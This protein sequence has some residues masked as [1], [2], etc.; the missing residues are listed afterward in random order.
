[1]RTGFYLRG[2]PGAS[3]VRG[4]SSR[5]ASTRAATAASTA[6]S[7]GQA[8][9][10]EAQHGRP[11]VDADRLQRRAGAGGARRAGRPG[12][13]EHAARLEGVQQRLGG[14]A[15]EGERRDVRR[16]RRPRSPSGARPGRR[17]PARR[18]PLAR[19]DRAG[20]RRA[21]RRRPSGR[22]RQPRGER[23]SRR[24][25]GR[26]SLPPRRPRSCP[27]PTQRGASRAPGRSHSAP[28]PRGPCSLCA[29]SGDAV[30][31]QRAR[32]QARQAERLHGVDV[33]VGALRS[34]RPAPSRRAISATGCRVPSSLFTSITATTA[35]SGAHRGGHGLGADDAVGVGR[36]DVERQALAAERLGAAHDRGVLERADD[37]VAPPGGAR[38][39]QHAQGVRL[40]SAAGE[41]HLARPDVQRRRHLAARLPARA[42]PPRPA[43]APRRGWRQLARGRR[44]ARP[45]PRRSGSVE[46][47]LSRY[48]MRLRQYRHGDR[49]AWPQGILEVNHKRGYWRSGQEDPA[50]GRVRVPRHGR[51][52]RLADRDA[53]LWARGVGRRPCAR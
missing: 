47:A 9:E 35:V 37:E 4:P 48:T 5:A 24:A 6:A 17:R 50:R 19:S 33:Q 40:G 18:A 20:R 10:R 49:A 13:R 41:Q 14:Q 44:A 29:E 15:R 36:D 45:A 27:P 2:P 46:A 23:R 1:M 34:P 38:R 22:A 11:V 43:R 21:P 16:A 12:R 26:F 25:P 7:V 39:P 8:R 53:P 52:C 28:A 30:R 31:A 42:P 3:A 51:G 32:P